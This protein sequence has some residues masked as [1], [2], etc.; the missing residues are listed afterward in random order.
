MSDSKILIFGIDGACWKVLQPAI[1]RGYMPFIKKLIDDG[2]SGI[3]HSTIPA[4]TPAAWGSFLT[5]YSPAQNQVFDFSYWDK[6]TKKSHYVNS[7]QLQETIFQKLSEHD[8][9]VSSINVPMTYPPQPINGYVISGIITPSLETNFT[10]PTILKKELLKDIPDYQIFN[11]KNAS[12]GNPF[13]SPNE[14]LQNISEII[15][16]RIKATKLILRKQRHDLFMLHFQCNDV[17]QHSLWPY[18]DENHKLYN[19]EVQNLI[20]EKYHKKLDS[21]VKEI[22][23]IFSESNDIKPT[24]I[25]ASDHGFET[26]TKRFNLGNWLIKENY[27]IRNTPKKHPLKKIT[28]ILKLGEFLSKF[29]KKDKLNDLEKKLSLAPEPFNWEK[30][31]AF[32]IG[33]SGE[34]YLYFLT[35]DNTFKDEVL[36]KLKLIADENNHPIIKYIYTKQ[37]LFGSDAPDIF[38]DIFIIPEKGISFT[39]HYN[40]TA[41]SFFEE[42]KPESD[43]H[44]G[45]HSDEGIVIISGENIKSRINIESN[46]L[47]IA[48]TIYHYLGIPISKNINGKILNQ[49]FIN[50]TGSI[51]REEDIEKK[52]LKP[53]DQ[54]SDEIQKRL[55]DLGYL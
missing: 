22:T 8:F 20:F 40:P 16:S 41:S 49:L 35:E 5:G 1:D 2:A 11:L 9:K 53:E 33:R 38:P 46:I 37:D 17:V 19:K 48:P 30:S 25:I 34:G 31:K 51:F 50:N 54:Q 24:I 36:T 18:L 27:L 6:K 32:S 43:F 7:E 47:D 52:E 26:H 14:F 28:R 15:D 13:F 23:K 39:G 42:V 10:Y 21:A 44:L 45:K 29:I 3:L 55:K 12:K 4:I